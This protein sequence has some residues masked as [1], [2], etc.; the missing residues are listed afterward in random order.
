MMSEEVSKEEVVDGTIYKTELYSDRSNR[1]VISRTDIDT[2][3]I[4]YIGSVLIRTPENGNIPV[5]FPIEGESIKDAFVVFDEVLKKFIEK[6]E[7]Q[8]RIVM[9][10]KSGEITTP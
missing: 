7:E 2:G 1:T 3:D 10:E 4:G 6:Q 9:P 8:S 5:E